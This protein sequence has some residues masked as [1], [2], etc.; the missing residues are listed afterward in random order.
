MFLVS[1]SLVNGGLIISESMEMGSE[2]TYSIDGETYHLILSQVVARDVCPTEEH[3]AKFII[4]GQLT[5]FL[6]VGETYNM[7]DDIILELSS[8]RDY[9]TTAMTYADFNIYKT[10]ISPCGNGTCDSDED[11]STCSSDCSCQSGYDCQNGQCIAHTECG[12]GT[13]SIGETCK[14]DNCC[15]GNNV[16]LNSDLNNCG[17][18]GNIC[19]SN[20][21]CTNGE[22][23]LKPVLLDECSTDVDCNDNNNYTLDQCSGTPKLCKNTQILRDNTEIKKETQQEI[24]KVEENKEETEKEEV[25]KETTSKEENISETEIQEKKVEKDIIQKIIDWIV[26]LFS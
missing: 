25:V 13:C 16:N 14:E 21:T 19:N 10:T 17:N 15:N 4:N 24:P 7:D 11:C 26:G 22:C 2:K 5:P 3:G 18:C 6:Y 1:I 9:P 23:I 20:Q 12:D 8:V